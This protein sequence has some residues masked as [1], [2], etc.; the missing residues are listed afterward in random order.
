MSACLHVSIMGGGRRLKTRR[1]LGDTLQRLVTYD[2]ELLM[3]IEHV[4][5][6]ALA[7]AEK[8]MARAEKR[9]AKKKAG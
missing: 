7:R 8:R 3:A 2:P 6:K 1:S 5:T 9:A 4:A